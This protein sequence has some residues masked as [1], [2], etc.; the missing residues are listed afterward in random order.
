[1]GGGAPTRPTLPV[2]RFPSA[3]KVVLQWKPPSATGGAPI[4]GYI[5]RISGPNS[6]RLGA[7]RQATGR[8]CTFDGL[9]KGS[10]YK[11]EVVARNGAADSAPLLVTF[12][13]A[14]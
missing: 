14:R 13:Q 5:C 12:R 4:T 8:S 9:K 6:T 1:M 2:L 7:W 10:K 11:V 3:R